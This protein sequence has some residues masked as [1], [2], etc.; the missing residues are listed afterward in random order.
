MQAL[1]ADRTRK[2]MGLSLRWPVQKQGTRP[3]NKFLPERCWRPVYVVAASRSGK[4][5]CPPR[6]ELWGGSPP[7]PRC[8]LSYTLEPQTAACE[9]CS[10]NRSRKRLGDGRFCS[11]W[12][13]PCGVAAASAHVTIKNCLFLCHTPLTLRTGCF[14]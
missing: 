14:G 4:A 9:V 6:P 1:L 13:Q 2:S 11:L 12:A 10:Q 3:V 5:E 7:A 8:M